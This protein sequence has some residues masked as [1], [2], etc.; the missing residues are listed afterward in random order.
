[1]VEAPTVVDAVVLHYADPDIREE[2][3]AQFDKND[4]QRDGLATNKFDG[5]W[6]ISGEEDLVL[7][8]QLPE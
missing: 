4:H 7:I 1:M 5:S 2:V 8:T 6:R 3:Q